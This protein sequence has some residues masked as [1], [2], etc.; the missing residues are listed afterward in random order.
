MKSVDFWGLLLFWSMPEKP[1]ELEGMWRSC[2]AMDD[3][4]IEYVV[5][6]K[7][8]ELIEDYFGTTSSDGS[9]HGMRLFHFKRMWK[10]KFNDFNYATQYLGKVHNLSSNNRMPGDFKL[11]LFNEFSYSIRGKTLEI[12]DKRNIR[13]LTRVE[14]PNLFRMKKYFLGVFHSKKSTDK[15]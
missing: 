2:R 5:E 7:N 10:L 4:D 6:Y 1:L 8:D 11:D 13:Y 3:G 12:K 15:Y 14:H 9:C